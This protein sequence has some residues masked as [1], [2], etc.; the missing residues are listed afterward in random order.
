[1]SLEEKL[2]KIKSPNLQSQQHTAVVLSAV[3]ETLT[4]QKTGFT[5]TAYFAALLAL[6][7]QA[8]SSGNAELAQ[9]VIYLLDLISSHVP[10][11]LLRSQFSQ[12]LS[13]IAPILTS[14]DTTAALLKSSIGVL[15]SLLLAQDAPGWA[16]PQSQTGPRQLVGV[17]L[18]L[19]MDPRPKIRKRS[20]DA[21]SNVLK[22]PPQGPA[23]DHPAADMCAGTALKDL[24]EASQAAGKVKKQHKSQTD[25]QDPR[26]MHALQLS[27]T[28]ASASGGWPSKKIEPL[29]EILM[30]I[31][32]S[33]NEFLVMGAFEVFE[34]IFEG[35][36]DEVSSSKL[37]RLLDA[38]MELQPS[39]ND[40]QL[41][42]PWIAV[43]SRGYGVSAQVEPEE[44][45][46][47][48]PQLFDQIA[49]FLTSA[50]H[51]IRISASECLISFF[52]NCIPDSV[53]V[54]PS[55]Y[56]EKILA[57]LG[58]KATGLLS[59]KYQ[60]AWMEVF[61]TLAALLGALRWR[62]DPYLIDIVKA[63]GELR[64]NES[65][66][67]KKE[68]DEVL[69]QAIQSLGP[70]AVLKVL[71]HNL[72]TPKAGQPGRAW[73]LP[74]LRDHVTN[75]KLSHFKTDL[76]ALSEAMY[77]RILQHGSAEKT[78]ETKIFE[79]IIAQVW[80]IF[81][82][83]CD[84]PLDLTSALDQKFAE[85][86]SNLLY[87]QANLRHDLCRG[88]QNLV[89]SNQAVLEAEVD[90]E[91]LVAM[92]RTSKAQAQENLEY[93]A[94]FTS[95]LLAVLFNVYSQTLPQHRAYILQCINSYLSITPAKELEETFDR[96]ATMV[97]SSTVSEIKQKETKKKPSSI[98]MPPTSHTLMDLI[99]ALAMYLPRPAFQ[100]LF[101]LAS[102][103]LSSAET[104]PQLVKKAYKIIPRLSMSPSSNAALT[105]R[106]EELQSLLL[107]TADRT[108][109]PARRDRL[110]AIKTLIQY[111]PTSE[112]HFIPS[113]LSEV[114]LA[115][116]D[117]N[118]KA[119]QAGFTVLVDL[120]KRL[121]DDERNPP[122]TTIKNSKVPG[123][124]SD[125]PDAPATIEEVF[126]MTSAGLAGSTPH[127][128]AASATALS[129]L[130][131]EFQERLQPAFLTELIATMEIF[132]E[133]NNR[134][135]VRA[136][137][138]CVKVFVVVCPADEV[139]RPRMPELMPRIARW[140]KEH[141]GRLRSK[142]K[143]I[144]ERAVRKFGA[145][146]VE[147]WVPE[148]ERKLVSH[149]RKERERRKKRK[150]ATGED[151]ED[152]VADGQTAKNKEF[153]NEYDE[154]VYGSSEDEDDFD[155]DD[156]GEGT[157][158]TTAKSSRNKTQQQR[159]QRFIREDD[160]DA[161]L[162]LLAPGALANISSKKSVRFDRSLPNG[163]KKTKAKV[164]EDGKLVLGDSSDD[165]DVNMDDTTGPT[166]TDNASVGGIN[167]Y[168][169]AITG[170]DAIR[171]GQKG[172]MKV[173]SAH[174]N[175]ADEAN[176]DV[177]MNLDAD[178]ARAVAKKILGK[179]STGK[180]LPERKGLGVGKERQN[181]GG[182]VDG[183]RKGFNKA[184]GGVHK[185]S[186]GH[187]NRMKFR[188]KGGRR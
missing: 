28:V 182:N 120:A 42:P 40:S 133:S 102:H 165:D 62:G 184:G 78:M 64:G 22:S 43:V 172:R 132:L 101:G 128:V 44:T 145:A 79:T 88:L 129:R 82:G 142:V 76:V 143:S 171:R 105:D 3:E 151:D 170:P 59:V 118:E 114:V 72:T 168:M 58:I 98:S 180:K 39:N 107:S 89:E 14:E 7:R 131:F 188:S 77:H 21:I 119:R 130:V 140:G 18:A 37:P 116:K 97:E 36:M 33:S 159:S 11:P 139:L 65:F 104:D 2:A 93:L 141:N 15:E 117:P 125:A 71:P 70:E 25:G 134:E 112:L 153:D 127:M 162:D 96:V 27:K 123:M 53:I 20:Q 30:S 86:V 136:V 109:I 147:A 115:C 63:I 5:P 24:Q 181:N 160:E 23:L 156:G 6:L 84:L 34:V 99:I 12:I 155:L 94:G 177:E 95:N 113:I 8:L 38:I 137:L 52:A 164:N 49:K 163:T 45:F 29:C 80:A 185:K 19:A 87:Q 179:N 13:Q 57:Q 91:D 74:L 61:K 111:L 138:G 47:K 92:R 69:G 68:A 167:A 169:T 161:P 122:G 106:N 51:N 50:S 67:G 60:G 135:I 166:D 150:T 55:I 75:T 110:L 100:R 144:V 31:S 126:T 81:P 154:A 56:D 1:M 4:E 66:H 41:L 73:L 186:S 175:R 17:L 85:M 32:R 183:R 26:I 54:E 103:L 158:K 149:I 48:L 124:P 16:L 121:V 176:M 187:G 174:R 152:E 9:S 146:D 157:I 35:L 173:S 108:P 148:T 90:D 10:A 46:A 83:Y 178:E